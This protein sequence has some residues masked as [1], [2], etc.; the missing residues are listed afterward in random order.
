MWAN[1][2]CTGRREPQRSCA[3]MGDGRSG[4]LPRL[5]IAVFEH[6]AKRRLEFSL[7]P[8]IVHAHPA[9]MLRER[10][11]VDRHSHIYRADRVVY[12]P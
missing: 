3:G 2:A 1:K 4:L 6:F 9:A 7:L 11:L 8:S 10:K 12:T 5:I